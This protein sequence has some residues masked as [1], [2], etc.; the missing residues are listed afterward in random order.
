MKKIIFTGPESSG[1]STLSG[2]VSEVFKTELV[3]EYARVYLEAGSGYEL[4]DLVKIAKEQNRHE[5]DVSAN[6]KSSRFVV[7]DTDLITIKIWSEYK[8]GCCHP[9]ILNRIKKYKHEDRLYFLCTPDIPWENDPQREHPE[10]RWELFDIYKHTL[11]SEQ[12]KYILVQGDL[13]TRMMNIL[14][15]LDKTNN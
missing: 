7:C 2:L 5:I 4:E 14:S 10:H 13:E 15:V 9:Y 6:V 11:E 12:L 1:K 3:L 8:Y